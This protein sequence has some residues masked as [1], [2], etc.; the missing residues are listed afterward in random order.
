LILLGCVPRVVTNIDVVVVEPAIEVPLPEFTLLDLPPMR[1]AVLTPEMFIYNVSAG[2]L[3][4]YREDWSRAASRQAAISAALAL[5]GMGH[6]P[7]IFPDGRRREFFS[8]KT[9]LRYHC[10]A[11]QS[12][13]FA[14]KTYFWGGDD[15]YG[16]ND[17][18]VPVF[19]VGPLDSLSDRHNVE[20]FLYIYGFE[21]KFSAER[22][23]I[24]SE[25]V[26][27]ETRAWVAAQEARPRSRSRQAPP[28]PPLPLPSERTFVALIL[29]DRSGR[30]LWYRHQLVSGGFD[31]RT[32]EDSMRLMGAL[33]E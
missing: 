32:E 31:M 17:G 27:R 21:E 1:L 2:G 29:A 9:R 5:T 26:E 30:I 23:Q 12:D 6:S 20:G 11:F 24:L 13:F 8:L 10:T 25:A 3:F 7:R 18:N 14:E 15:D 19:S 4:E 22:R 16:D 33:L 28:P